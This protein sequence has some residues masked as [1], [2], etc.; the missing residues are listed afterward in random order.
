MPRTKIPLRQGEEGEVE[1]VGSGVASQTEVVALPHV[2]HHSGDHLQDLSVDL[3][4]GL[5][6][7]VTG[8]LRA[9]LKTIAGG[10]VT[11]KLKLCQIS[12][13]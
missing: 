1:E 10:N 4:A 3:Q 11:S 9:W 12:P 7:P 6:N 5:F 13:N 8:K 2:A